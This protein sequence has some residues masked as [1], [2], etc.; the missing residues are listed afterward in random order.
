MLLGRLGRRMRSH[1]RMNRAASQ[2]RADGRRGTRRFFRGLLLFLNRR[3]FGGLWRR[4]RRVRRRY[5][6]GR[7]GGRSLV[8]FLDVEFLVLARGIV[9]IGIVH[10]V[11]DV[12][13]VV[14]T[15]LDGNVFID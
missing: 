7:H 3:A 13:P 14:L 15:K 4:G 12:L 6:N 11:R 1:R 10:V 2:W 8:A 9:R 5:W